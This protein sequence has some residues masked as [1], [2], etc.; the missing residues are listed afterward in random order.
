MSSPLLHIGVLSDTHFWL[1]TPQPAEGQLQLYSEQICEALLRDLT[2]S[3]LN[4]VVHLGD[5]TCGGSHYGMSP[6]DFDQTLDWFLARIRTLPCPV[7]ILSG[8]H[9]LKLGETYEPTE[10][11]L[12]LQPGRGLGMTFP[13]HNLHIELLNAQG[14][15]EQDIAQAAEGAPVAGQ[16]SPAELVRLDQALHDAKDMNVIVG[17]HQLLQPSV[18]YGADWKDSLVQNRQE[19][20]TIL[21]RHGNIRAVFQG[22]AHKYEVQTVPLGSQ[23][24]SFVIAPPLCKWPPAWL[25][26]TI[27][28]TGLDIQARYLDLGNVSGTMPGRQ[29]V[30]VPDPVHVPF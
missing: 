24:C 28:K 26:L 7:H 2:S 3:S 25:L 13:A 19:V 27:G 12:G 22:H 5:V 11:R 15:T 14:H 23:A 30:T 1:G 16:V 17:T 9:D 20:R 10:T 4:L 6:E 29:D 8:N 21:A 18:D